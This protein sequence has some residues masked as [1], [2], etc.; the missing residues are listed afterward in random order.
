MRLLQ[1]VLIA[2]LPRRWAES[3]EAHSRAWMVRCSC[4][5]ARSVWAWGDIRWKAT[6]RPRR[7]MKCPQCGQSSWHTVTYE[8]PLTLRDVSPHRKGRFNKLVRRRQADTF[9]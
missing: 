4:G 3:M 1:R 7:Y 6:G 5:L 9:Q 2:I 8:P